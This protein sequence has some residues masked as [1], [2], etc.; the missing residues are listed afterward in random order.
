MWLGVNSSPLAPPRTRSQTSN[1]QMHHAMEIIEKQI[2]SVHVDIDRLK[3]ILDKTV[4]GTRGYNVEKLERLYSVLSQH[5]YHHRQ[6][7]DK[8][9]LLGVRD[10]TKY[11]QNT[12]TRGKR[13]Y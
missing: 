9:Q 2:P 6:E 3:C 12:T 4:E 5:I 1:R 13:L 8:T 7:Y 10:C 11:I